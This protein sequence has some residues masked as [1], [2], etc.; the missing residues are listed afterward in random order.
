MQQITQRRI[1]LANALASANT[2][3]QKDAI[4]AVDKQLELEMKRLE[5]QHQAVQTEIEAV[6]KVIQKNIEQSFKII[7]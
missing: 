1:Q 3:Q 4:I 2:Q 6:Q 7:G 5:T